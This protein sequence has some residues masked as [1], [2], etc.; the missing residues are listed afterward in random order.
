MVE[1]VRLIEQC[2]PSEEEV[3]RRNRIMV[4]I[5]A[6]AYEFMGDSLVTDDEYDRSSLKI[7]PEMET[8]HAALDEFFREQYT[9]DSGMWIRLH[10]E[11]NKVDN[12][13]HRLKRLM[14]RKVE[15]PKQERRVGF[16]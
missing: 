1:R 8:G 15:K 2:A 6:Y 9:P 13:Y 7:R 4:T 14:N 16:W 11:L 5:W 10:P 3:E 12:A